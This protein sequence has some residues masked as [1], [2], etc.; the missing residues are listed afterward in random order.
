MEQI[1]ITNEIKAS[2]DRML[3]ACDDIERRAILCDSL[4]EATNREHY[5]LALH[6]VEL[7]YKRG[8]MPTS[9]ALPLA[10]LYLKSAMLTVEKM[11]IQ[12]QREA[13]DNTKALMGICTAPFEK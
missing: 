5:A 7:A 6:F 4:D 2:T 3:D 8:I 10:E 1:E 11:R 12:Q 9:S 13:N